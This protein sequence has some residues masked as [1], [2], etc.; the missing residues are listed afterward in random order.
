MYKYETLPE[1]PHVGDFVK[2]L[3]G[4]CC[5]PKYRFWKRDD[6]VSVYYSVTILERRPRNDRA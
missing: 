1:P 3:M 4:K 5:K 6:V 2:T